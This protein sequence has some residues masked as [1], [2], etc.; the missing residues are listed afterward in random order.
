VFLQVSDIYTNQSTEVLSVEIE[1]KQDLSKSH[2]KISK[3]LYANSYTHTHTHTHTNKQTSV[4][5]SGRDLGVWAP[6][7]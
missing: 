2:V 5:T 6:S 1:V 7:M 3:G 4:S